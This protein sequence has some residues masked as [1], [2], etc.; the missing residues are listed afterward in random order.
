MRAFKTHDTTAI[1][2]TSANL[3][4]YIADAHVP[5]HLTENYNGQL[6]GQTGIHT[7]WE[8]RIPELFGNRYNYFVDR[9]RYIEN[10]L[11]EAF[12][13]CGTSFKSVDTVL[14]FE[15]ILNKT[16]PADKKY[17][18]VQHRKTSNYRLFHCL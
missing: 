3:G 13:I 10:Q 17:N 15:R 18:L 8:S 1:L 7:L 6:T 9:A 11:A 16:F 2:N 14:R 12:K 4:H 5:L